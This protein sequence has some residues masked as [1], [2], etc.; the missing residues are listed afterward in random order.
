MTRGLGVVDYDSPVHDRSKW[1]R[2]NIIL[3][4]PVWPRGGCK[5]GNCGVCIKDGTSIDLEYVFSKLSTTEKN[6]FLY[7]LIRSGAE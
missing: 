1:E 2:K 4:V 5:K 6:K 3:G 7:H